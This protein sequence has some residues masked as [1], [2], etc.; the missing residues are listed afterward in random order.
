[1]T[2][3]SFSHELHGFQG[4]VLADLIYLLWTIA[5]T[6]SPYLCWQESGLG[7]SP[8]EPAVIR[9]GRHN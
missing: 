3:L 9:E 5:E 8:K 4:S 1:M 7:S 6:N 2:R